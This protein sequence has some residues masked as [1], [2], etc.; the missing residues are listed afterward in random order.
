MRENG[1]APTVG[2]PMK[3]VI[4]APRRMKLGFGGSGGIALSGP[5]CYVLGVKGCTI[6]ARLE[7]A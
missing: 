1:A 2:R 3:R 4:C 7:A 6:V 5:A